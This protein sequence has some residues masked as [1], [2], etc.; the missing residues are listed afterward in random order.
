MLILGKNFFCLAL[1]TAACALRSPGASRSALG[2]LRL[3]LRVSS[4]RRECMSVR[5]SLK[6][7]TRSGRNQTAGKG[8]ACLSVG[9][10][11]GPKSKC[12]P[13]QPPP[14]LR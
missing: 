5:T 8:T 9:F 4:G 10:Q 1:S 7:L 2:W 12:R 14:T 11:L 3:H 6:K 13:R